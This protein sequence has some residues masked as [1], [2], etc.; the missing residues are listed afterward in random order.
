M[1]GTEF[2]NR[3]VVRGG[4]KQCRSACAVVQV[5]PR[6]RVVLQSAPVHHRIFSSVRQLSAGY[7]RVDER[8]VRAGAHVALSHHVVERLDG[9]ETRAAF[10]SSIRRSDFLFPL[11]PCCIAL[12]A[13]NLVE[14]LT[15]CG[16]EHFVV[17]AHLVQFGEVHR[18]LDDLF[19]QRLEVLLVLV[20]QHSLPFGGRRLRHTFD[21]LLLLCKSLGAGQRFGDR[22][23]L[24]RPLSQRGFPRRHQL[25]ALLL[26]GREP[27]DILL[28]RTFQTRVMLLIFLGQ[29]VLLV[30]FFLDLRLRFALYFKTT[31]LSC[32]IL[33]LCAKRRCL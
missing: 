23:T 24:L 6:N 9:P 15:C 16:L 25:L 19:V 8:L 12:L 18:T 2:S 33:D 5:F 22:F 7:A 13:T 4:G 30:D 27:V 20:L 21:S 10:D 31:R 26:D 17:N 1:P 3:A 11:S 29:V 32:C 28:A 14:G